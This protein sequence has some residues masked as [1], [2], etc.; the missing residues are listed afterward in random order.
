MPTSTTTATS[1][2]AVASSNT[3]YNGDG[4]NSET[5]SLARN[6]QKALAVVKE[7]LPEKAPFASEL[8]MPALL[9][10]EL[11]DLAKKAE[12]YVYRYGQVHNMPSTTTAKAYPNN[13]TAAGGRKKQKIEDESDASN[14]SFA[15]APSLHATSSNAEPGAPLLKN[16]V[17]YGATLPANNAS[18]SNNSNNGPE[19]E[20]IP[21]DT[22][23][24]GKRD[25][26]GNGIVS[27]LFSSITKL[28]SNVFSLQEKQQPEEV[29]YRKL[30]WV[31]DLLL[32]LE[33][34]VVKK[35]LNCCSVILKLKITPDYEDLMHN[36]YCC[37]EHV[38]DFEKQDI[39]IAYADELEHPLP[40]HEDVYI[41]LTFK[42]N[43][44]MFKQILTFF[45]LLADETSNFYQPVVI[46]ERTDPNFLQ[47]YVTDESV[48]IK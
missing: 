18:S 27:S 40:P 4:G 37:L 46:T 28:I 36:Y 3:S 12:E 39:G 6:L 35:T 11:D 26:Q 16:T 7:D 17:S 19:L 13:S 45:N 34:F 31:G 43:E 47:V 10:N 15:S 44:N 41:M 22:I 24:S 14:S 29:I 23:A 20:A 48:H 38:M 33:P 5:E 8:R 25:I 1:S 32:A 21:S 30:Q 9:W 2:A 42:S